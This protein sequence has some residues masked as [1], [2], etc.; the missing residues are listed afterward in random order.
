M[1]TAVPS[2][3]PW[4]R[5]RRR[6]D[7][8]TVWGFAVLGIGS[9]LL[10][11]T[12]VLLR[13]DQR[14]MVVSLERTA[15]QSVRQEIKEACGHLPGISVVPDQGNPDPIIQG[16]FPVRLRIAGST[17]QQEAAVYACLNRFPV[18]RGVYVEGQGN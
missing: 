8:A 16:R 17:Q 3:L 1:S 11:G 2:A 15:D 4:W 9:I 5:D 7:R 10:A 18:V 12:F 6:R 13:G 14:V